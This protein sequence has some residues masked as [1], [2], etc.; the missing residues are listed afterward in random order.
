MSNINFFPFQRYKI[1]AVVSL[2][3]GQSASKTVRSGTDLDLSS[4]SSVMY[5]INAMSTLKEL[6]LEQVTFVFT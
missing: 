4:L 1:D 5:S 6:L 2:G 3:C